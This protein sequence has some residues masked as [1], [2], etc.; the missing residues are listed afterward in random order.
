MASHPGMQ[1]RRGGTW[2]IGLASYTF[3]AASSE[4]DA[5]TAVA[6]ECADAQALKLRRGRD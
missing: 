6:R 1:L 4:K 2:R 3:A 5:D